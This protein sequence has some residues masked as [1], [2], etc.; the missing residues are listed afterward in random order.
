MYSTI[1]SPTRMNSIFLVYAYEYVLFTKNIDGE[2]KPD[3]CIHKQIGKVRVA[4]TRT[5]G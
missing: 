5:I 3:V 1:R 2:E 4:H